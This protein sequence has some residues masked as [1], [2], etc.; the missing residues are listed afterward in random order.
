M[1]N[2]NINRIRFNRKL[3][4]ESFCLQNFYPTLDGKSQCK[5]DK[6]SDGTI[7]ALFDKTPVPTNK[8]DVVCPH[9]LELKWANGCKFD[10]AWCFLQ[11]TYRFHPEWKNGSPNIKDYDKIEAHVKNS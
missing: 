5:V 1:D 8:S 3:R 9:F 6:I 10:C 4:G 2:V 7:I 11:G